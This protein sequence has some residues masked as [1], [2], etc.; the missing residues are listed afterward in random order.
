MAFLQ[1]IGPTLQFILGVEGGEPLTPLRIASFGLIWIGV[2]V[3]AFGAWRT[4]QRS[5]V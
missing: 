5:K 4:S 2:A 3:F 1:F